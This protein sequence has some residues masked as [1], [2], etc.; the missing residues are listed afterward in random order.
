MT[1]T[2]KNERNEVIKMNFSVIGNYIVTKH[3]IERYEER[4]GKYKNLSTVE[5]IRVDLNYKRIKR[6]VNKGKTK[7]VYTTGNIEFIFE[8]CKNKLYLKTVIKRNRENGK[9]KI[10]KYNRKQMKQTQ[11]VD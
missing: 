1:S 10:E 11:L 7:H 9:R 6:I 4:V 8:V 5:C 3:A 2:N